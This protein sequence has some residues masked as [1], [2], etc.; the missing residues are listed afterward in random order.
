MAN[1]SD[2][3]KLPAE[4]V[5]QANNDHPLA[6]LFDF[7]DDVSKVA[8]HC[9][10]PND[11]DHAGGVRVLHKC[12]YVTGDLHVGSV[13]AVLVDYIAALR[14]GEGEFSL[15]VF[16]RSAMVSIELVKVSIAGG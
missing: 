16:L 3:F 2:C 7:F 10:Q 13:L 11:I 15:P 9:G 8:I 5:F 6:S 1:L 4:T 14:A 12:A